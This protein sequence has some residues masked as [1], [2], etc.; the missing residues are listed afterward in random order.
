MIDILGTCVWGT[1]SQTSRLFTSTVNVDGLTT[2]HFQFNHDTYI[3][4]HR[5]NIIYSSLIFDD[6]EF[7]FSETV[8]GIILEITSTTNLFPR[9]SVYTLRLIWKETFCP[10]YQESLLSVYKTEIYL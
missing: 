2:P 10:Y 6:L 4:C 5:P 3:S 7:T 8:I 9:R 1:R